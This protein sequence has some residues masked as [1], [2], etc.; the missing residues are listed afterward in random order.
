MACKKYRG[1]IREVNDIPNHTIFNERAECQDRL[2]KFLEKMGYEYVS[3]SEAEIKRG[4]LSK[5][6]FE[7]ELIRFLKKQHYKFKGYSASSRSDLD[8]VPTWHEVMP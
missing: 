7:D 6:I 4:A 1:K 5:V 2:I 3:R 8:F